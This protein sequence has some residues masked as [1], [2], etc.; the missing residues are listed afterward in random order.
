MW[1]IY[2]RQ[3]PFEF[4]ASCLDQIGDALSD[5]PENMDYAMKQE[6]EQILRVSQRITSCMAK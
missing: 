1:E 6:S 4:P 5:A 3:R 2:Q